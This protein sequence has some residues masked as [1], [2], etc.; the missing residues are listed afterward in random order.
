[1][2]IINSDIH[3]V[4]KTFAF[5]G[6]SGNGAVGTAAIF[7]VSGE[8]RIKVFGVCAEDLTGTGGNIHVGTNG[9]AESFVGSTV[10]T[11]IDVNEIWLDT[12]PGPDVDNYSN[13]PEKILVNGNDVIYQISGT[14][15][16][17]GTIRFIA[18]WTPVSEDGSVSAA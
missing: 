16:T 7:S 10:V 12:S 2:A 4:S 14:A 15:V 6:T 8:V 1:M 13:I 3:S 9:S 17:D 5:D 18:Y 11:A